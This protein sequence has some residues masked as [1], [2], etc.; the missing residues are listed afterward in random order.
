MK[1]ATDFINAD[2]RKGAEIYLKV[3]GEKTPVDEIMEVLGRS[4]HP[5][6]QQGRRHPHLRE[7]HG[8]DRH[9][10]EPAGRLEGH[11]LPR[12]A[13][14]AARAELKAARLAQLSDLSRHI[15]P[16]HRRHRRH[17]G[18]PRVAA[19]HRGPSVVAVR[20]DGV[21][22]ISRAFPT[23]RDLCE[24]PDP[25]AAAASAKAER[26]GDLAAILANTAE[27]KREQSAALSAGADRPAG[28]QGRGRHLRDLA[29]RARDRGAG[30]R[31]AGTRRAGARRRREPRSAARSRRLKPGS[32]QAMELKKVLQAKGL[33]SQYLE[34]GIGPDAEI[35]T[36]AQPMSAVGTGAAIG[37]LQV[38]DLEQPRAG[39]G[40]GRRT[41]AARSSARRSATT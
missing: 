34:V 11:V 28:D 22:D 38:I 10:E 8:Q 3:T 23:M 13:A 31:R 16:P 7:L 35:F 37:M 19:G 41:R 30:A 12:G 14:S 5:V 40:R 17:A 24:A 33:W 6:Q 18:R 32:P 9:A 27:G 21:F 2:K 26:I 15:H 20:A 4:G 25:A 29:A 39:G 1:E 36:K